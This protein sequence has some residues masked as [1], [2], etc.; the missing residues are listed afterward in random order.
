[1]LSFKQ[2]TEENDAHEH[3]KKTI[4]NIEKLGV[5]I[6]AKHHDNHIKVNS[7]IVPEEHRNKELGTTAMKML[8]THTDMFGH[9]IKLT[10]DTAVGGGEYNPENHKRL[11]SF[12]KKLGFKSENERMGPEQGMI[13]TTT[14]N[15]L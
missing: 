4:E 2:F 6:N 8:K 10:P 15:D 5:K 12:Y 9:P 1:M 14:R 7:I 3:F 11:I 13:Y